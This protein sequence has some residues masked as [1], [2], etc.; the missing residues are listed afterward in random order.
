MERIDAQN[1]TGLLRRHRRTWG[2]GTFLARL[3]DDELRTVLNAGAPV[4]FGRGEVLVT[5]GGPDTDVFLLLSSTVKVTTRTRTK[6]RTLIAVRAGGDV[7]GELATLEGFRRTA[8][9]E[10]RGREPVLAVKVEGRRFLDVIR[11]LPDAHMLLTASV[12]RKL[13]AA[14]RRRAGFAGFT[15]EIR[16]ARVIADMAEDYGVRTSTFRDG[17]EIGVDLTQTEWGALIGASESTAF[18]ALKE[19]KHRELVAVRYRRIV[20]RDLPGLRAFADV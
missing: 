18:R 13:I 5:E 10:V 17:L 2:G 4:E 19:L 9:V 7:I 12:A 20:V 14:T 15:A 3:N 11:T 16:L 6:K 1:L 8:T